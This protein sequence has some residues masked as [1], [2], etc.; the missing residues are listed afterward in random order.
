MQQRGVSNF[1]EITFIA[2]SF[3]VIYASFL[4][5][6]FHGTFC[7]LN[8]IKKGTEKYNLALLLYLI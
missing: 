5:L 2:L 7:L 3:R 1:A 6:V 8:R 4:P